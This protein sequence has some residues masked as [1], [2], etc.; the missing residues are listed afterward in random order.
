MDHKAAYLRLDAIRRER[1]RL[2]EETKVIKAQIAADLGV[3]PYIVLKDRRAKDVKVTPNFTGDYYEAYDREPDG[4]LKVF[5]RVTCQ[6]YP[7]TKGGFHKV[8]TVS[9]QVYGEPFFLTQ[10]EMTP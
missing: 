9:H 2:L 3:V 8:K 1:Y 5:P 7:A 6:V 10:A 4:S